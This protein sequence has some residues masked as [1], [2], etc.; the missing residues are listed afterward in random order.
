M[1]SIYQQVL[2]DDF[3]KLHP[4]IQKRFGF[5]SEDKIAAIGRGT[6]NTIW[7][8]A[9]YTLPFLMVGAWRNIMFPQQGKA[10]PFTIENYAYKDR[11]GRET[12][13]WIRT[14]SFPKRVRRFDATMILSKKRKRIVDY[15][16]DHQHLAVDIEMEVAANG[17]L[18]LRSGE[19][20]FYEG[21]L[22]FRFPMLFSGH[23][24]VCEWYDD[25]TE[26]FRISVVVKNPVWGKLFGYE[27]HFQVEYPAVTSAADIPPYVK[28]IREEVRE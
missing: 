7:H 10:I 15:L 21:K 28:P 22:A 11:F 25:H 23:A 26:A 14:Y 6:M 1:S 17:G 2:G 20:R 3:Y 19:Q 8:G 24:E 4:Q 9:L 27:G 13:T 18:T 16:G 5:S 12:V